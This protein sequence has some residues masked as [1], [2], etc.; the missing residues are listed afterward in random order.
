MMTQ[1]RTS[2]M[3]LKDGLEA[4]QYF[5]SDLGKNVNHYVYEDWDDTPEYEPPRDGKGVLLSNR[6]RRSARHIKPTVAKKLLA[7][8][9]V[10]NRS[11]RKIDDLASYIK[12]VQEHKEDFRGQK[13]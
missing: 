12:F 11:K 7:A 2:K 5:G 13:F 10:Y 6:D 8:E 1:D 9:K 4:S 3:T